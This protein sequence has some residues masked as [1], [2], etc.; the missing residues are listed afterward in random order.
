MCVLPLNKFFIYSIDYTLPQKTDAAICE[1]VVP[2][3]NKEQLAADLEVM[4]CHSR[5]CSPERKA[6]ISGLITLYT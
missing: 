4:G 6:L 1:N 2:E 5:V 3:L